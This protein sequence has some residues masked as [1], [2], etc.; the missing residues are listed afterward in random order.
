MNGYL[1]KLQYDYGLGLGI[2][3]LERERNGLVIQPAFQ[4]LRR[5]QV[6]YQII[7]IRAEYS[8]NL[9]KDVLN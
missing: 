7:C 6:Q 3:R 2:R 4:F 5:Y 8:V 1:K 9:M